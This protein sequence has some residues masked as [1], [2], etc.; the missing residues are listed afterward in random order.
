M[1]LS[2][3]ANILSQFEKKGTP[4]DNEYRDQHDAEYQKIKKDHT[5]TK[6]DIKRIVHAPNQGM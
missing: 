5:I 4:Q 1:T 6:D 2:K 3:A